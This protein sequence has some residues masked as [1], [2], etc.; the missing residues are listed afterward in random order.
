T[1][2]AVLGSY[3]VRRT[4]P[5]LSKL[6]QIKLDRAYEIYKERFA[7][8]SDFTFTFVGSFK[9]D[10]IKPLLEQYLGALP[11]LKRAETAKDLG[12]KPPA[13][14]VTKTVNKG[15]EQKATVRLV[16]AGDY[17]YNEDTNNQ[18]QALGEIIQIKL[19]ERLRE[20][21]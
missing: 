17:I 8:A 1:V 9:V 21:E 16:F 6:D 5:T 15:Q 14:I 10:E 3:N 20:E 7:D 11:S 12:I 19:I 18:L 13:G 2:S 4:G